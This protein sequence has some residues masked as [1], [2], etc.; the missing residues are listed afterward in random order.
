MADA[1]VSAVINK[2]VD[3]GATK[4]M[5]ESSRLYWLRE[6]VE[7][8]KRQ[9][10]HMQGYLENAE[11]KKVTN[12]NVVNLIKD[13]R[14]L[15]RDVEDILEI[16]LP[17]IESHTSNCLLKRIS[18]CFVPYCWTSWMF[19]REIEKIKRRAKSIDEDRAYYDIKD[20]SGADDVSNVDTR[21]TT[22]HVDDPIIVGFEQDIKAL[23]SKLEEHP[24]VSVVGMAG[25]GKTTLAKK[26]FRD[27]KKH[28]DCSA[29]VSVSQKPNIKDLVQGIANQ[30]GLP[31]EKQEENMKIGSLSRLNYLEIY[32]K[33]QVEIPSS[34]RDLKNLLTLDLRGCRYTVKLP[35]GIWK[36]EQL[37]HLLLDDYEIDSSRMRLLCKYQKVQ[38]LLPNLQT[39]SMIW[40]DL[41]PA[42][43][44]KL[45]NLRKLELRYVTP[46]IMDVLCGP[47]PISKKL[48][49]L[50]LRY[51]GSSDCSMNGRV[52]LA[53]YE[54]LMKL[55]IREVK[56]QQL[57]E[58]PPSLIKLTLQSTKLIEDPMKIL[59]NLPKL[60]ILHLHEFSYSGN[61]MD[62]SGADSFPQLEILEL[63]VLPLL[64]E[65]IGGE[66]MGMPKLKQ[67]LIRECPGLV[68]I[69]ERLQQFPNYRFLSGVF[70]HQIWN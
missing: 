12:P 38:V 29:S 57:P 10:R 5:E 37:R 59:K 56:M 69:P 55:S 13:I 2:A 60:K 7:W 22:L 17:R 61:K 15:V 11:A 44:L 1:V 39:L 33:S 6:D 68:R 70:Y 67:L 14:D 45:T 58:L 3:I 53:K 48:E 35:V 49:V 25:L 43:L 23:K 65:L 26:V 30:V 20:I 46:E 34:I 19:S 62:C 66:Q 47:E 64:K 27:M 32:S 54:R 52:S 16:Y 51:W 28:F 18:T 50:S 41:Q 24:L 21:S 31:K 4:I 42:W 9:M 36:M 8:L 40:H 63:W